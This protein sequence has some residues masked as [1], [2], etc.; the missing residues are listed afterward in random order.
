VGSIYQYF[1]NK[2]SIA[3]EVAKWSESRLIDRYEQIARE[4]SRLKYRTGSIKLV[5]ALLDYLPENE[6]IE[7]A[8]TPQLNEYRVNLRSNDVATKMGEIIGHFL[9]I[10]FPH[11]P[12]GFVRDVGV[13]IYLSVAAISTGLWQLKVSK[14][15]ILKRAVRIAVGCVHVA[16]GK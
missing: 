15:E 8:V 4:A 7:N 12:N 1:R 13:D 11:A 10:Y 14:K 2:E 6:A 9:S 16:L 5:E 3:F